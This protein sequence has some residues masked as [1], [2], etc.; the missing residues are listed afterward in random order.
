MVARFKVNNLQKK[1][2]IFKLFENFKEAFEEI[3]QRFKE[4]NCSLNIF[5]EKMFISFKTNV[6]NSDY[7][8]EFIPKKLN[9]E[10]MIHNLYI[11]IDDLVKKNQNFEERLKALEKSKEEQNKL[12]IEKESHTH[13]KERTILNNNDEIELLIRFIEEND[14][15]KKGIINGKLLY[16]ASRDGYKASIFI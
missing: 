4:K 2:K 13:F 3:N 14:Q 16:R 10:V 1:A 15:S 11:I 5:Q 8:L 12:K 9:T 6:V 7:T